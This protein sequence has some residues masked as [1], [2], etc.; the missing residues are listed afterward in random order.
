V[1]LPISIDPVTM[2]KKY[3]IVEGEPILFSRH[4]LHKTVAGPLLN[5]VE[6]AGFF[7]LT[8]EEETGVL[9]LG[10]SDSLGVL[11]R[12]KLDQQIISEFLGLKEM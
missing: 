11:S 6:S 5:K 4:I 7:I 2:F 1:I 12:P 10:E 8:A 9:C 3:I